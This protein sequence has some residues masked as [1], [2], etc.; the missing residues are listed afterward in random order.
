M[1]TPQLQTRSDGLKI[2][3]IARVGA[4]VFRPECVLRLHTALQR[5]I[6]FGNGFLL[7]IH[8]D[9][10]SCSNDMHLVALV[11]PMTK[12]G[13]RRV[14]TRGGRG[15]RACTANP[16]KVPGDL[17]KGSYSSYEPL[18]CLGE[19]EILSILS[20]NRASPAYLFPFG[21]FCCASETIPLKPPRFI[22]S[23]A[24]LG[25]MTRAPFS[26]KPSKSIFMARRCSAVGL[27]T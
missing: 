6:P 24:L 3:V 9:R 26:F 10:E 7:T 27:S 17:V 16:I 20:A 4:L 12:P 1:R 21:R 14:T 15:M 2:S 13:L 5:P 8:D 11:L 25:T 23:M 19:G 18:E 22:V